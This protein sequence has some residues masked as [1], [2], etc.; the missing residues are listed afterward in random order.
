M[1]SI[2]VGIYN[3]IRY[4][5]IHDRPL[6]ERFDSGTGAPSPLPNSV[7]D[8]TPFLFLSLLPTITHFSILCFTD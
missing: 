1:R 5:R 3:Y 8:P 4:L 6:S 7:A 2:V